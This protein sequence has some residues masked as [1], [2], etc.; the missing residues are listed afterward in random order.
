M[1]QVAA[2][3]M[4]DLLPPMPGHRDATDPVVQWGA[5]FGCFVVVVVLFFYFGKKM[6]LK[7]LNNSTQYKTVQR[8]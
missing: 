2:A 8:I 3:A 5:F 4:P 7:C 6:H 1:P